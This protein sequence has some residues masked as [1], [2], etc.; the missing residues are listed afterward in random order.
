MALKESIG[1]LGELSCNSTAASLSPCSHSL[2]VS[3][4]ECR[5]EKVS[6][7]SEKVCE[8]RYGEEE[9][10]EESSC[11]PVEEATEWEIQEGIEIMERHLPP[12]VVA[13]AQERA[14]FISCNTGSQDHVGNYYE[15]LEIEMEILGVHVSDRVLVRDEEVFE[16]MNN[17]LCPELAARASVRAY[18]IWEETRR[19]DSAMNYFVAVKEELRAMKE[20]FLNT[21]W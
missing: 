17:G 21:T 6:D 9:E 2:Q 18:Y 11:L 3:E 10:L 19:E 13:R 4:L 5:G 1:E 16:A 14:Y 7:L 20:E 12:E 8:M 15:A